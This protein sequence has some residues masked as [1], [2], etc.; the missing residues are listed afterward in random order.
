MG[1]FQDGY[2][3]W[4]EWEPKAY[5]AEYYQEVMPDERFAMEFLVESLRGPGAVP[6]ALD[7]G[8]GPTV[9]HL[10]PLVPKVGEIHLAEYLS[11]NREEVR[12]WLD[13]GSCHDW[14][15]F[16]LET[17]R[18]EGGA[19]GGAAPRA[20]DAQRRESETR[21]RVTEVVFADAGDENPLGPERR[22]FYP[23][24]TTHYCAEGATHEKETWRRYMRNIASLVRPGGTLILS[25]CGAADHYTVGEHRFP[26]A[27]VT[28]EDVLGSLREHG[29][30]D[31][32]L[33]VRSVPD[34]SEQG[35]GSVIFARAVR[36]RGGT[37]R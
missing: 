21:R 26:C 10:F 14:R 6:V 18:L 27:G 20:A 37:I 17:L 19:C 36:T 1:A 31:V 32:D 16:A 2:A 22:G 13:G 8:C 9:H 23:L 29:F 34:H 12:R 3:A 4:S 11:G 15:P 33:R 25:A 5:L 35:Y 24:V 30:V 7:F 28:G